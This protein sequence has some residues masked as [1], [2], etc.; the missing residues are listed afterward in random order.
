MLQRI[1]WTVLSLF[2]LTV[3]GIVMLQIVR[4]E[5]AQRS[6]QSIY[7]RPVPP[8][9][10]PT[11]CSTNVNIAESM[12]TDPDFRMVNQDIDHIFQKSLDEL[13]NSPPKDQLHRMNLLGRLLLYDKNLSV[14]RNIACVSCHDADAGF[15]SGVELWNRTIVANPGSVPIT[16]AKDGSPN[17]RIASRK[18]LSYSYAPFSPIL[19]Y[20]A[21]QQ[22][23]QG[24]N[25]WDMRATGLHTGNPS[26]EQAEGP[27]L[28]PDEMAMADKAAVVYRISQSPYRNFFEQVWGPQSFAINWPANIEQLAATPASV[29]GGQEIIPLTPIERGIVNDTYDHMATAIAINEAGPEVSPFTSKFDYALAHPNQKVLTADELTGW[30]LFRGKGKCNTCHTDGTN[31]AIGNRPITPKDIA[32]T[33]PLFTDFTSANIGT[34]RNMALP[35]LC[36]NQPDQYGFVTNPQGKQYIDRGVGDFLRGK[37]GGLPNMMWARY[38]DQFDGKFQVPTLRNVDKRPRP[39]F[40]KSYGHNGYFKSLK[41]IVHFYNTRDVLPKCT[42]GSPG[43]K[44]TCWPSSEVSKNMNTQIGHLGLTDKEENQIVAFMQTLTDGYVA[45]VPGAKPNR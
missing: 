43:E 42:P 17:M 45:P 10:G 2:V 7:T 4:I 37:R 24:G 33:M 23:F 12:R 3:F 39:G 44:V 20:N 16:N 19:H 27:P 11:E 18:P 38:A 31:K 40:V 21:T 32:N 14:N 1:R 15:T 34:P 36:E 9:I 26:I 35:F 28:D 13:H 30:Q 25:F 6:G 41:E 22:D 5:A 29:S 8:S